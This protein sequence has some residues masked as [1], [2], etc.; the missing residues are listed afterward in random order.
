MGVDLS[1][2]PFRSSEKY[3]HEVLN[4]GRHYEHYDRVDALPQVECHKFNA[5]VSREMGDHH[6]DTGYGPVTKT[7]YGEPVKYV[8]AKDLKKVELPG[9]VGAFVAALNDDVKIA[10]YWH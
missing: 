3:C 1:L 4:V 7:P 5:Y 9:P 6:D 10:L 2:L 8:L